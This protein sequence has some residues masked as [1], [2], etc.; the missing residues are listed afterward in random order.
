[1][2]L[3]VVTHGMCNARNHCH[4]CKTRH[5]DLSLTS[6]AQ[7]CR[8]CRRT[9]D[10]KGR[11]SQHVGRTKSSRGASPQQAG[12]GEACPQAEALPATGARAALPP[13]EADEPSP[14]YRIVNGQV[15]VED[16]SSGTTVSSS[17]RGG[18]WQVANAGSGDATPSPG[19]SAAASVQRGRAGDASVPLADL[20]AWG[21]LLHPHTTAHTASSDS[22]A[23][24][25]VA[26]PLDA[27]TAPVAHVAAQPRLAARA[28][29]PAQDVRAPL[30]DV[31]E[32][33]S[34][35]HSLCGSLA[36]SDAPA[37]GSQAAPSARH[38][39]PTQKS[40]QSSDTGS[41]GAQQAQTRDQTPWQ[42][43]SNARGE[44]ADTL[45]WVA[46]RALES[47]AAALDTVGSSVQ[48]GRGP[49][50]ELP[51][52]QA[53]HGGH[54]GRAPGSATLALPGAHANA[55]DS[56]AGTDL[57][58]SNATRARGAR[59]AEGRAPRRP[60]S[61]GA[62]VGAV[63]PEWRSKSSGGTEGGDADRARRSDAGLSHLHIEGA[64]GGA[65]AGTVYWGTWRGLEVAIKT[66]LV[67][68]RPPLRPPAARACTSTLVI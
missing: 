66:V 14:F 64:I 28:R 43:A 40:P 16:S 1:M 8:V 9:H 3:D 6:A 10:L 21:S 37:S 48:L 63:P 45:R 20:S 18:S 34:E 53:H 7:S 39:E 42:A 47:D 59:G 25:S 12:S 46:M 57:S 33:T 38:A 5:L 65:G 24:S 23:G 60:C 11:R 41:Q 44:R 31:A 17:G 68:V 56:S 19:T 4:V 29:G 30:A 27:H 58:S 61:G 36:G 55:A 13:A 22:D 67:T 49:S 52:A 2:H 32:A 62:E 54:V 51:P 15:V 50:G 35:E 26:M